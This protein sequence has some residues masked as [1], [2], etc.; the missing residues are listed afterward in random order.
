VRARVET[1]DGL[2]AH[3]DADGLM[4]WLGTATRPPRRVFV[5]HGEPGPAQALAARIETELRWPAT[6]P[7][8]GVSVTLE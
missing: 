3:A 5:V 6:V 4:R 8:Y 2:S 1:I 7:A